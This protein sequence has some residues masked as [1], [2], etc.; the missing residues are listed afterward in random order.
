MDAPN[1][2][3][4]DQSTIDSERYELHAWPTIRA[5]VTRLRSASA[6]ADYQVSIELQGQLITAPHSFTTR[7]DAQEWA[8][9]AIERRLLGQST[10]LA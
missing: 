3:W 4:H 8:L 6:L 5:V 7:G 9:R 1:L 10:R 2:E